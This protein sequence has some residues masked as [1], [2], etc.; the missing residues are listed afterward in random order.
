MSAEG[1]L[2]AKEKYEAANKETAGGKERERERMGKKEVGE[3]EMHW[4]YFYRDESLHPCAMMNDFLGV[5][6]NK[7][8]CREAT[9]KR[10]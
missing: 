4:F 6:E 2:E 8:P 5:T 1:F 10:S 7:V 9:G 3:A